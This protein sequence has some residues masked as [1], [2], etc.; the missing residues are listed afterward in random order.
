MNRLS[1]RR[2]FLHRELLTRKGQQ[3]SSE[4]NQLASDSGVHE[5]LHRSSYAAV[6]ICE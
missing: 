4:N 2:Y 5:Y 3:I 6:E 1:P